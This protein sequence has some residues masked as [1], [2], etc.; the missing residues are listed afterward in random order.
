MVSL[1]G[2]MQ[3]SRLCNLQKRVVR[4]MNKA[5]HNSHTD[6]LFK[7]SEILK[8]GDLHE[9][10]AAL[11]VNDFIMGRLPHSFGDLFRFNCDI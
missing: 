7:K 2:E 5:L 3:A 9:H 6:P 4:I 8:L 1:Y 10:Q 11:L